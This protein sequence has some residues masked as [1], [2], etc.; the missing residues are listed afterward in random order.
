LNRSC[1]LRGLVELRRRAAFGGICDRRERWII[2]Q[3][4]SCYPAL[5]VCF[6][7]FARLKKLSEVQVK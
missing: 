6:M 1:T 5:N 2:S 4:S 7:D 3:I